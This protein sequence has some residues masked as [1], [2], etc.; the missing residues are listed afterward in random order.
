MKSVT[1]IRILISGFRSW[2][3]LLIYPKGQLHQR[4]VLWHIL[5]SHRKSNVLLPN[6][7]YDIIT[8][9]TSYKIKKNS[10]TR[11]SKKIS[12]F[13]YLCLKFPEWIELALLMLWLG[14]SST[15]KARRGSLNVVFCVSWLTYK[16]LKPWSQVLS[17]KCYFR[18]YF[19]SWICKRQ[20]WKKWRSTCTGFPRPAIRHDVTFPS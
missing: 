19:Q 7:K 2:W 12:V 1:S 13:S 18:L 8:H 6:F 10:E 16:I 15:A 17:L 9:F 11:N 3:I 14:R 20:N 5:W 4:V